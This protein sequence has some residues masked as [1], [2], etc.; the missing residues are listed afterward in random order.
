MRFFT[1][2]TLVV[3]PLVLIPLI[4]SVVLVMHRANGRIRG[5]LADNTELELEF[6]HSYAEEQQEVLE[7]L[8][9]EDSEFYLQSA[10]I[11]VVRYARDRDVAG[12][13]CYVLGPDGEAIYQ[14]EPTTSDGIGRRRTFEPWGWT[15][16]VWISPARVTT[17]L[18]EA[19]AEVLTVVPGIVVPLV[20][21]IWWFARRVSRPIE[22]LQRSAA[23]VGRG[24]LE[25]RAE[26]HSDDEI[27]RLAVAFNGMATNLESLTHRL[28][29]EVE[30]R[31]RELRESL[32]ELRDTQELLIRRERMA[33]LGEL[34]AGIAHE[35]NTPVGVA[36]TSST[37]LKSE[38]ERIL[39]KIDAGEADREDVRRFLEDAIAG[40]SIIYRGLE[41]AGELLKSFRQLAVDQTN[42]EPRELL[43][44]R[45]L[46]DIVSSFLPRLREASVDVHLDCPHDL[47]IH[48]AP[49]LFYQVF[50]NLISNSMDHGF[51][52][53][54]P[55]RIR[56][57]VRVVDDTLLIDY[58]DDGRGMSDVQARRVFEPFYTTHLG[59]GGSGL[60][61]NIVYNT[62]YESLD[63]SIELDTSPG[64]GVRFDIR[65]PMERL[66]G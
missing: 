39:A 53:D 41:R 52:H 1:K 61:M 21:L 30:R 45:Y 4:L 3:F 16:G 66:R 27:G 55:G 8:D 47:T 13:F 24:E 9:L 40:S 56:I 31:T 11:A 5:L 26:V 6:F 57:H 46:Q 7:R 54:G 49:S 44:H 12:G 37:F 43:L 48:V 14:P 64:E 17:F 62:V 38:S 22:A 25:T 19:S 59:K 42:E 28:E 23:A 36:V 35:I 20:V 18:R 51:A 15:L 50:T 29:S 32:D 34:V 33:S 65:I 58:S 10:K 63:G 2:L 60:G